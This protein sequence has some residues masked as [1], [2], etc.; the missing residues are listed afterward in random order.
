VLKAAAEE[1]MHTLFTVAEWSMHIPSA[2]P[3]RADVV[4]RYQP[5]AHLLRG[6][7]SSFHHWI[8][9]V[10]VVTHRRH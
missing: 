9:A 3:T 7:G 2:C 1:I 8:R 10:Q 5:E 4:Q 6:C